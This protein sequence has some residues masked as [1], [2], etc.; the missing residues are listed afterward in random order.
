MIVR[1]VHHDFWLLIS[2][3]IF[4]RQLNYLDV[5]FLSIV[6]LYFLDVV[7]VAVFL[8]IDDCNQSVVLDLPR[9]SE[10]PHKLRPWLCMASDS[11]VVFFLRSSLSESLEWF[12]RPEEHELHFAR[13]DGRLNVQNHLLVL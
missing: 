10:V 9:A 6:V 13:L 2:L 5:V 7:L 11:Q 3:S 4:A 8:V 12:G 1:D